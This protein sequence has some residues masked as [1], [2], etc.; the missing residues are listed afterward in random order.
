[1]KRK[2]TPE[3]ILTQ[4][5]P[6][7]EKHLN[8]CVSN[9]LQF[10][11]RNV[12]AF[13]DHFQKILADLEKLP[14]E[15]HLLQS[16]WNEQNAFYHTLRAW[17]NELTY[18]PEQLSHD[19]I[20]QGWQQ[21]F[22]A[23]LESFPKNVK[24]R[25]EESYWEPQPPDSLYVELWKYSHRKRNQVIR[26]RYAVRNGFRKILR[27][28]PL[29]AP[30]VYQK[31]PLPVFSECYLD[32]PFDQ[33]L[34]NKWEKYLQLASRQIDALHT[35]V[36]QLHTRLIFL[37][38]ADQVWIQTDVTKIAVQ[39]K[40]LQ[41]IF[42][43]IDTLFDET[44]AFRL[45]ILERFEE[46][47]AETEK[48]FQ[49]QWHFAGTYILTEKKIAKISA[50]AQE[51]IQ[52][53]FERDKKA[54]KRDFSAERE[55]WENEIAL[56]SIQLTIGKE[57]LEA[58]RQFQ[59]KISGQIIPVFSTA[60]DAI[61]TSTDKFKNLEQKRSD[62]KRA[63]ISE[64][65]TL[66]K[67]LRN[68]ILPEMMDAMLE[69]RLDQVLNPLL[70]TAWRFG[71]ALPEKQTVFRK[72][73]L[74]HI[75]PDSEVDDV[76][77]GELFNEK[78][79]LNLDRQIKEYQQEL[80]QTVENIIRDISEIDQVVE[81]NLEAALNLLEERKETGEAFQ[82]V[83]DGLER[84]CGVVERF[85]DRGTQFQKQSGTQLFEIFRKFIE[86]VQELLDNE[87]LIKL[88]IQLAQT[89]AKERIRSYRQQT[90][91]FLKLILPRIWSFLEQ[92]FGFLRGKYSQLRKITGLAP[93]AGDARAVLYQYLSETQQ[94]ISSLPY[95]YQRLFENRPLTDERFFTG[96]EEELSE[97]SEDFRTWQQGYFVTTVIIGER[98]SGKTTVINFAKEQ[99]FK[100]R[101]VREIDIETTICRTGDFIP[102]LQNAFPECKS[103]TLPEI[104]EA[105]LQLEE[106]LVCI[107]ENI[108]K[109]F[110]RT[111]DGFDL[112]ERFLLL[113]SRTHRQVYWV[114]TCT[115]YSWE[116]LNK[117]I[118]ISRYFRRI[119]S[120]DNLTRKEMEN[121]ILR[122]HRVTGY[123]LFFETPEK[124]KKNRRFKK[125]TGE[126]ERQFYLREVFFEELQEVASGN[127][128]VAMLYWIRAIQKIEDNRLT[129]W[130]LIDLDYSFIY[131]LSPEELFTIG[132]LI[133]H[134]ILKPGEHAQVF[135]Q[136]E[137]QSVM[138]FNSLINKGIITENENGCRIHPFLYRPASVA[139][140]RLNIIH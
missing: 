139:L 107:V 23:F 73:D 35:I 103:N 110:L 25:L 4:F 86:D 30:K 127:V 6:V 52:H 63:I 64:N 85:I 136:S 134:E 41:E 96:R 124:I 62:L 106:P 45:A 66:Q 129:L 33:F 137:E 97:L 67:S 74:E 133:Q 32:V 95:V 56:R 77:I 76:P 24:I 135:H 72:K 55:D 102:Y 14:R 70:E 99:I 37:E 47:F 117:V 121:V 34:L 94:K 75:P 49:N 19:E 9:W 71:K 116:Y 59:D 132:A 43:T 109:L 50:G 57:Y 16:L 36:Q 68:E 29:A 118:N 104:E 115:L 84:A 93:A 39:L 88:K 125:L 42:R 17:T 20:R 21:Q 2:I 27:R 40:S 108:Q 119:L 130:P 80:R 31:F 28:Q 26:A 101:P 100:D 138:L 1:M 38:E 5:K 18:V 8:E 140:K 46:W 122:R 83:I 69:A 13:R 11:E 81:F 113:I 91:K 7:A 12:T 123:Q 58:V 51:K 78:L 90:W 48:N 111:V 22:N 44:T 87:A 131:Q 53:Q 120:L 10:H 79:L 112:L 89:K 105:L 126:E 60:I 92:T 82:T 98:G 54:W 3:D 65:R 128:F 114:L 15:D 61:R